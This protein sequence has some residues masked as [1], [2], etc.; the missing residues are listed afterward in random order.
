[1]KLKPG[2]TAEAVQRALKTQVD[3]RAGPHYRSGAGVAHFRSSGFVYRLPSRKIGRTICTY[4]AGEYAYALRADFDPRVR[5]IREQFLTLPITSSALVA[6]R[7]GARHPRV[8]GVL[9]PVSTDFLLTLCARKKLALEVKYSPD[10]FLDPRFSEKRN[11]RVR[12]QKECWAVENVPFKVL[13]KSALDKTVTGNLQLL[14]Y[15]EWEATNSV[16]RL[17]PSVAA[18]INSRWADDHN[19]SLSDLISY[20][21]KTLQKA[22][23]SVFRAAMVAIY[24]RRIACDLR[25]PLLL[26]DPLVRTECPNLMVE[27]P[28]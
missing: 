4:S 1:M 22:R 7:L 16:R 26:S 8:D 17:I 14:T 3:Q 2:C 12:L 15:H 25:S 18:E 23:D 11:N 20:T 6:N 10:Y 24:Q 13:F 19:Q 28:W 21:S 5:D 9:R 27:L